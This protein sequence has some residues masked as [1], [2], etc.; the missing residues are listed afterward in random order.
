MDKLS[1]FKARYEQFVAQ[2]P[3]LVGQAETIF[4]TLSLLVRGVFSKSITGC[5]IYINAP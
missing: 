4:R 2:N 5:H 1:E 3:I